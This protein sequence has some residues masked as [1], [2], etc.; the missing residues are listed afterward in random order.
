MKRT[1][2]LA[3]AALAAMALMALP[4][5]PAEAKTTCKR[6]K[7]GASCKVTYR[8]IPR[9]ET[10]RFGIRNNYGGRGYRNSVE[11]DR[12]WL[13][14]DNDAD[15]RRWTP[16][17]GRSNRRYWRG[18]APYW[19]ACVGATHPRYVC[20]PWVGRGPAPLGDWRDFFKPFG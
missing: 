14:T 15:H 12:G 9:Y 2:A 8:V 18:W 17:F 19:R 7:Y 1:I 3:V 20:T 16:R 6:S 10:M 13:D 4:A 11:T 5:A